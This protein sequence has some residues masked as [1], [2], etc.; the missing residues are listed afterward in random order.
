MVSYI[1]SPTLK[2]AS[3]IL[4]VQTKSFVSYLPILAFWGAAAGAGAATFTENW[5]LFQKT[6]YQHIPVLG[7]HW[8]NEVDPQDMP[9]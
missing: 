6:F 8:I 7:N 3:K 9:Q 5:P 2:S 4:G 1:A